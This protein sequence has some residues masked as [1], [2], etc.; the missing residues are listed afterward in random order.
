[1][2]THKP[3]ERGNAIMHLGYIDFGRLRKKFI[4][5]LDARNEK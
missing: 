2:C 5:A 1:M 3:Y 4:V